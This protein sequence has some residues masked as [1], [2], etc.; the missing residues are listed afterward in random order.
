MLFRSAF[1]MFKEITA[2]QY[3]KLSF[4]FSDPVLKSEVTQGLEKEG[5][6]PYWKYKFMLIKHELREGDQNKEKIKDRIL[7]PEKEMLEALEIK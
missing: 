7:N 6:L 5:R 3:E 4:Y 2:G 1:L